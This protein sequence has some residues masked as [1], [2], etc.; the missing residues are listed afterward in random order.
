MGMTHNMLKEKGLPNYL[1]AE[2]VATAIYFIN[3]VLTKAVKFKTPIEAWSCSKPSLHHLKIFGCIAYGHIPVHQRRKLDDRSG[4][5]IFIGYSEESRGAVSKKEWY[6]D[7]I[8]KLEAIEKHDTWELV[9][10]P[11]GRNIVGL[12]WLYKTKLVA[13]GKVM[14]YKARL[15]VKGY[16]QK[17]GINYQETFTP[18][19]RFE[20]I[21]VLIAVAA[22]R[23]WPRLQLDVKTAFL[24]GE[25][26]E[27]IYVQQL[28]GFEK[29]GCEEKVYRLKKALYGLKQA[30]RAWYSRIDCY[31]LQ[32]GY[33]R[34]YS[35]PTLVKGLAVP[36]T[37]W[38]LGSEMW[39]DGGLR[40]FVQGYAM[41]RE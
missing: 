39:I 16:S 28:E 20:T 12:K 18:V 5:C 14:R 30:S 17:Q 33:A 40:V 25:L 13:K 35:E 24:N 19:A 1:W 11:T 31:F 10:R 7:M 3:R 6:D 36:S 22:Q 2:G 23:G 26:S 4:K 29:K 38:S 9:S 32:N 27:E 34:S 37:R 8:N 41:V 15:V 21:R